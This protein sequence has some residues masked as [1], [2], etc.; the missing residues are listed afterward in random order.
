MRPRFVFEQALSHFYIKSRQYNKA[1]DLLLRLVEE[2][3]RVG[4]STM[5][6]KTLMYLIEVA[7][8]ANNKQWLLIAYERYIAYLEQRVTEDYQH[9][10]VNLR[11]E[12]YRKLADM[13]ALTPCYNRR[14]IISFIEQLQQQQQPFFMLVFDVDYFKHINDMYGH[15]VG[16]EILQFIAEHI[17]GYLQQEHYAIARYGGD[18]FI[19]V[20]Q[21]TTIEQISRF[22]ADLQTLTAM[23]DQQQ[24]ALSFSIGIVEQQQ[25]T[26]FAQLFAKANSKLY[27]AKSNG[28]GCFINDDATT[29]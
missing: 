24:H 18:E 1:Y 4:I 27:E 11:L 15:L 13:D 26:T 14:Y 21:Q 8:L 10:L 5:N 7:K 12:E 22:C 20:W 2:I 9:E 28:R 6:K 29:S 23:I 19:I 17:I 16:D 3:E 25:E